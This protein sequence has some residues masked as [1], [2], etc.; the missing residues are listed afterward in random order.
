VAA[1]APIPISTLKP[2]PRN[3]RRH[4]KAQI[5]HIA[6]SIVRF[7]FTNPV[8]IA[9]DGEIVA[10][11]GRIAAARLLGLKTVPVL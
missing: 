6:A 11:H 10:G 9:D 7:G 4:S 8:L 1:R 3:A 2:Y 5:K